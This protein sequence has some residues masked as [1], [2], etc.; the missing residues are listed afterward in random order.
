MLGWRLVVFRMMCGGKVV[1]VIAGDGNFA[2]YH[3]AKLM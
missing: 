2:E 1:M 3:F